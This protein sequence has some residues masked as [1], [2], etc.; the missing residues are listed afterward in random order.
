MKMGTRADFYVGKGKDAEW[1][2]SIAWD[3]YREGIPDAVLG[4]KTELMFRSE[5][6]RFFVER[7]DVTLPE[8]GWPWP[9]DCSDTTD[10]SY[11]FFDGQVWDANSNY[12]IP[13]DYYTKADEEIPQKP[14]E[15]YAPD[16]ENDLSGCERVEFPDMSARRNL[17]MGKRSGLIV[18]GGA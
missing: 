3:G 12:P 4:A 18:L 13:G 15:R 2:G 16:T 17:T 14:S 9:W 8:Q 11:W 7:D 1:I 10:C 6:E 5:L